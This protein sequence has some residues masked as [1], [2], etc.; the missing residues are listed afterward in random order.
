[1]E[2][3]KAPYIEAFLIHVG[4]Q[5][6]IILFDVGVFSQPKHSRIVYIPDNWQHSY[7]TAL[8]L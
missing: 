4:V 1:V 2:Q 8:H 3:N 7:P 6:D 5:S